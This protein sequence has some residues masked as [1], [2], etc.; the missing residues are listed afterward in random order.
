MPFFWHH[1]IFQPSQPLR[2]KIQLFVIG[3]IPQRPQ[4][5][6]S[7]PKLTKLCCFWN[8]SSDQSLNCTPLSP[9]A[10]LIVS[11]TKLTQKIF[12][13]QDIRSFDRKVLSPF[14]SSTLNKPIRNF[15]EILHERQF[16]RILVLLYNASN[17]TTRVKFT[18]LL[19]TIF[20]IVLLG[21]EG[22]SLVSIFFYAFPLAELN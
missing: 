22:H 15:T 6:W 19:L 13:Y 5:L 14:A 7:A 17:I 2:D 9:L 20:Y 1:T 18:G 4:S 11:D 3:H 10:T 21:V 8:S 12:N 16:V